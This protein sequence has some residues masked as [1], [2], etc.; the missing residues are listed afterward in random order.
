MPD[1]SKCMI[2]MARDRETGIAM[3]PFPVPQQAFMQTLCG[4]P[5]NNQPSTSKRLPASYFQDSGQPFIR[6]TAVPLNVTTDKMQLE[7]NQLLVHGPDLRCNQS[8]WTGNNSRQSP[9]SQYCVTSNASAEQYNMLG[10]LT[11]VMV[12]PAGDLYCNSM[13]SQICTIPS[14]VMVGSKFSRY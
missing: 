1:L 8:A 2:N 5:F 12:G 6:S 13:P 14:P 10:R 4:E 7:Q 9:Y 3:Q 11:P